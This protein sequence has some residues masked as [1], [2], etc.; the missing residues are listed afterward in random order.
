MKF[1][2][3][4]Q[5][6]LVSIIGLMVATLLT[7]C[8]YVTID[9]V[10]IANSA[11]SGSGSSGQIQT[12]DADSS[13]GALRSGQPAVPSG[14]NNPVALAATAD[15]SHLYVVNEAS[16]NVVHFAIAGD[17]VLTQ[18]DVVTTSA[19]P[20]SVAV[21][22][23]ETYLYVVS[24][25][26]PT[27]LTEYSLSSGA[28]GNMVQQ[29][30]LSLPSN[31]TD[32]IVP[33]GVNVL[34]N[35]GA[36]YVSAYDRSAYNPGGITTSTAN[37]GW[38]FGY[39]VASGGS[40]T[41]SADSPYKAGVKPSAL[42]SDPTNRFLYVTDFASNEL[43]GYTIQNGTTL[44][45]LINGPFKTGNEPN[46]ICIDPRG[47]YLYITN[48][49]D[50]SVSAYVISLATGTPSAAVNVTGSQANTTD[51]TPVAVIVDPALGRY[52][53]TANNLG[54]SVSGFRLN[55]TTGALTPTQTTPYPT[56]AQ[57]AALAAV[58]HGN[59][60]LQTTSP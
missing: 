57:P 30:T 2:K 60:S 33:T 35:N 36:V 22:T 19:T 32:T 23:A 34:A 16:N 48:G 9:Y 25:P 50:S 4:S 24:G 20:V 1:N 56:G 18:K 41:P 39:A 27:V 7:S 14:G 29:V 26:N 3:L 8:A 12:F 55:P 5:L 54:N 43:I 15:Y 51:T 28:I 45:F 6:F 59:H 52:V 11:G 46:A 53:Y 17:G 13:T 10:F 47:F 38:V 49:L 58:P 21:N 42:V 37:P 44:D 31:P 40:L